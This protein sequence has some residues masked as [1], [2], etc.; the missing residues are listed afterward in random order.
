MSK[1]FRLKQDAIA[2]TGIIVGLPLYPGG[3][4]LDSNTMLYLKLDE[5]DG[6]TA[7]DYSDQGNDG[8]ITGALWTMGKY[9]YG[10]HFDGVNDQVLVPHHS[11]LNLRNGNADDFCIEAWVKLEHDGTQRIVEKLNAYYLGIVP[12]GAQKIR[13]KGGIWDGGVLREVTGWARGVGAWDHVAFQR[14][15]DGYLSMIVN[16]LEQVGIIDISQ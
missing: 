3:Y 15:Q 1:V 16:G 5:G 12:H 8:D 10:L 9:G 13:F 7:H 4:D 14:N 11:T 6:V 2:A